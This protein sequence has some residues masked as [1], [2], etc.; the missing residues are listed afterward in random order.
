[1]AHQQRGVEAGDLTTLDVQVG[2]ARPCTADTHQD[3]AGARFWGGDVLDDEIS[4]EFVQSRC[5]HCFTI[6]SKVL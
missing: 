6:S 4:T 5:L 3:L 1:V 2:M